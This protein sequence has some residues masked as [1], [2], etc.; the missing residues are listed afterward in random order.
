M[1]V[2]G[3]GGGAGASIFWPTEASAGVEGLADAEGA[4]KGPVGR[5]GALPAAATLGKGT[6][7]DERGTAEE[8]LVG[9]A[10]PT[11]DEEPGPS[12]R[13]VSKTDTE[14]EPRDSA[15]STGSRKGA[16]GTVGKGG[17]GGIG[18]K[19]GKGRG[20]FLGGGPDEVTS[21]SGPEVLA[22]GSTGGSEGTR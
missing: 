1:D 5:S 12:A 3:S 18:P 10:S 17:G 2:E 6:V 19:G 9:R 14:V 22:S 20:F 16:T 15:R 8:G 4:C 7:S 13:R 11:R 21:G